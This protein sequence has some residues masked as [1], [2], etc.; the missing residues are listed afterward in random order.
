MVR[1]RL[2]RRLAT[3]GDASILLLVAPA[4]FGKSSLAREGM[5][6]RGGQVRVWEVVAG[7]IHA[8]D[9]MPTERSWLEL[10][11]DIVKQSAS[12]PKIDAL[13]LE[14]SATSAGDW[15]LEPWTTFL[16]AI[17]SEVLVL[18]V[19]RERPE[20]PLSSWLMDGRLQE[21]GPEDLRLDRDESATF[22]EGLCAEPHGEEEIELLQ[23]LTG[24]WLAGLH[25]VHDHLRSTRRPWEELR[26][27]GQRSPDSVRELAADLLSELP[28]E[29]RR[30]LASSAMLERL[31]PDLCDHVLDRVDGNRI[32][33]ELRSC[34]TPLV[35]ESEGGLRHRALFR[36]ILLAACDDPTRLHARAASWFLDQRLMEEAM[37]HAVAAA[38][39]DLLEAL[40]EW[41]IQ[42]AFRDSNFAAL[43]RRAPRIEDELA[44]ERPFL[45]LFLAW[46]LFHMGREREGSLHLQRARSL[47][48]ARPDAPG[49]RAVLEHAAFL[50][51]V[52]LRLEGRVDASV[53]AARGA[54]MRTENG[55]LRASLLSQEGIGLFRAGRSEESRQILSDAVDQAETSGHHMAFFGS[56][57]TLSELHLLRGRP[58]LANSVLERAEHYATGSAERSGP[59]FGYAS[60]A[61]GRWNLWRGDLEAARLMAEKGL[62]QGRRCDNIRILHYG[63]HLRA[64]LELLDGNASEALEARILGWTNAPPRDWLSQQLPRLGS[65]VL[66]GLG[67]LRG[68]LPLLVQVGRP[69]EASLLAGVWIRFLAEWGMDGACA[70]LWLWKAIA[71]EASGRHAIACESFSRGLSGAVQRNQVGIFLFVGPARRWLD[72]LIGRFPATAVPGSGWFLER[73]G[74]RDA[75]VAGVEV[76]DGPLSERETEVLRALSSGLSNRE[77]GQILFVAESTVKT[78]V[79]NIFAKLGVANRTQAAI[80]AEGLG[81]LPAR[82]A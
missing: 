29:L 81:V 16:E 44:V 6:L 15:T 59:V 11:S 82:V 57:Y 48:L 3:S 61:R 49:S 69:E 70:E 4:G 78:H 26:S 72:S 10:T 14:A 42:R 75:P 35:E 65:P 30:F 37:D 45:S 52:L 13:V 39:G 38:D 53:Q 19:C 18:Q 17:S 5:K 46:S 55:F 73:L 31:E 2:T 7:R 33:S 62:E 9:G 64:Q 50:R 40:A 51:S 20:L 79:K 58:D 66:S 77:I 27:L 74:T 25:L 24:G 34:R 60:I 41:A 63:F 8:I 28:D 76:L 1:E 12:N 21:L 32:L 68:A 23:N 43:Q 36:P 67:V 80:R 56:I 22:L 47:A 54:A 71:E